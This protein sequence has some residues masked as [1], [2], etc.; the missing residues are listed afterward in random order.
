MTRSNDS[1]NSSG[2]GSPD[3][4][5]W[6]G[7]TLIVDVRV[8][9]RARSNDF[10]IVENG[11]LRV[12]VTAAPV[13]NAANDKVIAMLAKIFAVPKSSVRLQAGARAREKR[14]AIDAPR[15][16]PAWAPRRG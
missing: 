13:G 7:D 1:A 6:N 4:C 3:C 2:N 9:P 12:R 8:Q 14:F 16:L 11:R 15:R 10:G 5:R